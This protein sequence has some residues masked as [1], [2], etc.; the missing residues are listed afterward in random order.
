MR[1]LGDEQGNVAKMEVVKSRLGEPDASGRRKPIPIPGTEYTIDVDVVVPAL[2]NGANRLLTKLT[3][4]LY[5]DERGKILVNPETSETSIKGVYAGG[6]I[7]RGAA[8]VI[9]AMGDGRMA[10][11]AIHEYLSKS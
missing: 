7:V 1:I 3:R 11:R 10:A 6:D 2:G 9:L 5:T 8:T 4:G